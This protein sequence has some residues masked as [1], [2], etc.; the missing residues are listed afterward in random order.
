MTDTITG[1]GHI[2]ERPLRHVSRELRASGYRSAD[3]GN[4]RQ[5]YA[6]GEGDPPYVDSPLARSLIGAPVSRS[7]PLEVADELERI[8]LSGAKLTWKN[9]GP[10][11]TQREFEDWMRAPE[12]GPLPPLTP[13]TGMNCWEIILYAGVKRG[14][15]TH[16]GLHEFYTPERGPGNQVLPEWFER[17]PELLWR[18]G[19]LERYFPGDLG[20]AQP[21][22][23]DLV[24][25]NQDAHV[26]MATGRFI[27]KDIDRS[28]EVYSF[29]PVPGPFTVDKVTGSWATVIDAVTPT[30]IDVLTGYMR[31]KAYPDVVRF[32][33][34]PW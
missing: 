19:M 22:R 14:V 8:R 13:S 11:E 4:A 5:L 34:G 30:S 24:L 28:P 31:E 27:G 1:A 2:A 18:H 20:S 33:R 16:S 9:M 29:W 10:R 26:A 17:F 32:G 7:A 23:G 15:F 3:E 6:A 21:R 25:W 12:E